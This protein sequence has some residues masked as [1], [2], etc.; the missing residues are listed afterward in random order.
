MQKEQVQ[1]SIEFEIIEK[2]HDYPVYEKAKTVNPLLNFSLVFIFMIFAHV[3]LF[4]NAD[5]FS[6]GLFEAAENAKWWNYVLAAFSL[7]GI[8]FFMTKTVSVPLN[9]NWELKAD[10]LKEMLK[11]SQYNPNVKSY[12]EHNEKLNN[13][14][15]YYL[16]IDEQLI[17]IRNIIGMNELK[18]GLKLEPKAVSNRLENELK[19]IQVTP[20]IP[21]TEILNKAKN[22]KKK[23]FISLGLIIG[24]VVIANLIDMQ[25]T[26]AIRGSLMLICFA[27]FIAMFCFFSKSGRLKDNDKTPVED[28]DYVAVKNLCLYRESCRLY[29]ASV[30]Q[31]GRMLNERDLDALSVYEQLEKI[32]YINLIDNQAIPKQA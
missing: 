9:I 12:I 6:S 20:F 14:D 5:G 28:K 25:F 30:I 31:E 22:F 13:R 11:V 26:P 23:G 24:I 2:L 4:I 18:E 15:Y 32:E 1:S 10:S 8:L 3:S 7:M 19:S 21:Q 29:I 27:I 16:N 17:I